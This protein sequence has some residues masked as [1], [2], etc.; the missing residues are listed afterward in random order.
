YTDELERA[1][2]V[3]VALARSIEEKDPYTEGHCER[4][5]DYSALLGEHLGLP[6]QEILALRRAG[7]VHDIGKVAVPDAILLKPGPL[8]WEEQ[9]VVHKH[10]GAGENICAPFK[11]FHRVLRTLSIRHAIE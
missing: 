11:S 4:L 2:S 6:P 10:Q 1:E 5:A 9:R 7:I 8:S 3:L